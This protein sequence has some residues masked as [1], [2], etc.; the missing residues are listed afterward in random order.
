MNSQQRLK[1]FMMSQSI[2][3][4]ASSL[5]FPFYILFLKNVG[6]SFTTFG[7]SYGLFGLSSALI[8]PLLGKVSMHIENRM[9]MFVHCFGMALTLLTFPHITEVNQVYVIQVILGL[10]GALQKHG[11][12]MLLVDYTDKSNRGQKLGSYHFWTALF[13][14]LAV[15]SA[16]ILADFF[17]I[18]AIFYGSSILYF[19][20]GLLLLNRKLV[21]D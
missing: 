14:S 12:K 8:Y 17:T 16:G 21:T 4:F 18:D 9:F 7:F 2:T 1:I 3:F 20:S 5:I 15:M 10:L 19:V 11:E 13:S 6:S